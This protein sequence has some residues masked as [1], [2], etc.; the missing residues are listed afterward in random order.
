MTDK[1]TGA[2]LAER[3][4]SIVTWRPDLHDQEFWFHLYPEGKG[5]GT[6]DGKVAP[7]DLPLERIFQEVDE[8]L[9]EEFSCDTTLCVAGWALI[10]NGY[11]IRRDRIPSKF[12]PDLMTTDDYT[13]KDGKRHDIYEKAAELL[14]IGRD[15]A[16]KLF[17]DTLSND[18]AVDALDYL[19]NGS[20]IDWADICWDDEENRDEYY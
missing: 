4:E 14:K 1:L 19:S 2:A 8:Q 9:E 15:D 17:S 6:T 18:Q 5:S 12:I 10:L 11:E 7:E 16:E 3:I 20:Q 13:I